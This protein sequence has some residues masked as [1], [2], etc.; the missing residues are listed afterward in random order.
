MET[1]IEKVAPKEPAD[2]YTVTIEGMTNRERELLRRIF[3][4]NLTIPKYFS[5]TSFIGTYEEGEVYKFLA[6][7]AAGVDRGGF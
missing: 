5:E 3:G 7:L 6:K 2:T 1:R 4:A